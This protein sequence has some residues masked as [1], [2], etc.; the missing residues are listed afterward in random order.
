MLVGDKRKIAV[1]GAGSVGSASAYALMIS[2]LVNELVLVDI[3]KKRAEGEAMDLAHGASFV[4]PIDIYAGDYDDCHDADVI[5]F[6]AGAS[7]KPGETRLDLI[8]KNLKVLRE[9]LPLVIGPEG[10]AILLMVSNPVDVLT[11]AALRIT[12]L[13]PNRV[14]G[15]GTVLDSSRFRFLVSEKCRVEARNIHAYVVGEHG[16][17]EVLLWSL[18]NIAGLGVEEFCCAH[19][20][21]YLDK[22]AISDQVRRAGYEIIERKG[23]TYYAI[24]LAVRRICESIVRDENSVLTVSGL[25]DGDYGIRD[26]C[27]SLPSM[28]NRSGRVRTLAVPLSEEE[29]KALRHSANVLKESIKGLDLGGPGVNPDFAGK[30]GSVWLEGQNGV[31]H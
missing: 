3:D 26:V 10:D 24:G 13:P 21:P 12:G 18:A 2:G 23:A 17:S 20:A 25:I 9:T 1:V 22:A 29:E 31:L 11:Y 6:S 5:V 14:M 19:G 30:T 27:L 7:Q 15:S 28:V 16:D 4:S 8:H